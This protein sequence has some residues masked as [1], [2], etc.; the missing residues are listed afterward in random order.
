MNSQEQ[1]VDEVEDIAR[2]AVD[3]FDN[4]FFCRFMT[5]NGG[6]FKYSFG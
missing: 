4:L 1:W 3:Y 5:A 2:V 6:V